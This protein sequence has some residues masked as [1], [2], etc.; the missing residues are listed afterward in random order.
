MLNPERWLELAFMAA[1]IP[2][3]L[4]F[5]YWTS[6]SITAKDYY[7][8]F[9]SLY[10]VSLG[11]FLFLFRK[12]YVRLPVS[13]WI[14]FL[15]YLAYGT[16]RTVGSPFPERAWECWR[17]SLGFI[18]P[19]LPAYLLV[20]SH[21]SARRVLWSAT[22]VVWAICIYGLFQSV[23]ENMDSFLGWGGSFDPVHWPWNRVPLL[24]SL[25]E[26]LETDLKYFAWQDFPAGGP[27][28]RICSTFGNPT[29]LAGFL[30][31][32]PTL[33]AAD[34]LRR[35]ARGKRL[36]P[37]F[38]TLALVFLTMAAT[39]SKGAALGTLGGV[40]VFLVFAGWALDTRIPHWARITF[41]VAGPILLVATILSVAGALFFVAN[42]DDD[43]A[44]SLK[45]VQTRTITYQTTWNLIRHNW[46]LGVTPGNFSVFFPDYLEGELAEEYGWSE[47]P[48]EKV[49]EHAHCEI[50]EIWA[51]LGI[52]GLGLFL[53]FLAASAV[54]IWKAW[55]ISAGSPDGWLLAGITA[56]VFGALC[57]NLTSVSLRWTPS[58][59]AFWAMA[60]G[61]LGLAAR[62]LSESGSLQPA[63][64]WN[65]RPV[66]GATLL[67][68][69]TV[70]CMVLFV[71]SAERFTADWYFSI[72][73]SA[74]TGKQNG[75]EKP[76]LRS[77]QLN[78]DQPATHYLLGG[79]FFQAGNYAK[80]V[81]HFQKVRDLRGD[82]VVIAENLATAYFKI[83]TEGSS[84]AERQ[85]A[86]L[87]AIDLYEE[88]LGRHPTFARLEDYLARSYQRFGLEHL[89]KEHRLKAIDLY[90]KWFKWP[91]S[92]PRADYALD[93]GKNYLVEKDYEKAF[94]TLWNAYRWELEFE[95]IKPALDQLFEGNP[96][97]RERWDTQVSNWETEKTRKLLK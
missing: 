52:V 92:F 12:E 36:W 8:T 80:A 43:L 13:I 35:K 75:S 40:A 16:V 51:D 2:I 5:H 7:A 94:G 3:A 11:G 39:I 1:F 53:L 55:R 37:V 31:L 76:L 56:G 84:E 30:V 81:E 47:S 19:I 93:L 22:V 6:T 77:V 24:G 28:R 72:G 33:Y 90:E 73:R 64:T 66:S 59:W 49:M 89:S 68:C 74:L 96:S 63:R 20:Q 25:M 17:T 9:F 44:Q 83:S 71:P 27:L 32:L 69:S 50:L 79:Y 91:K 87:K 88:S 48:E 57:E 78:P 38:V 41:R 29:F 46:L 70:F 54:W 85:E 18:A 95:K 45:S 58:A 14:P 42:T 97:L 86:L 4:V 67:L 21:H 61:A 65:L 26:F 15:L 62:I 10:F 34:I 82:V 60:G 23:A